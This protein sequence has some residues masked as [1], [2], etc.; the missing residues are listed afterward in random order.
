MCEE[1]PLKGGRITQGVFRKGDYV[2]RPCCSN[3]FFAH[4]AL[5][6]LDDKGVAIAPRFI[7]LT[8]DRREITTFLEGISPTDLGTYK[9]DDQWRPTDRQLHEAGRIIKT[10]HES[11]SDFPGCLDGQTVCHNDLSPCNFMFLNDIPY[12]VFDWDAAGIGDPLDDIAYAAWM[13][14]CIGDSEYTSA[15]K[16]HE[17]KVILDSYGLIKSQRG[18]LITKIC[19]QMQRVGKSLLSSNNTEGYQW[20]YDSEVH[21]RKYQYEI[22]QFFL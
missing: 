7:G 21:L 1:I 12:A 16:G 8:G 18:I 10:L 2:L 11:L 4:E 9:G 13:W 17:I 5:K 6:W 19:E 20:A 15:Q 14:S 22:A 3:S